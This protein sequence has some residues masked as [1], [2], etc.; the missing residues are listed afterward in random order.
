[1]AY[2]Y[3]NKDSCYRMYCPHCKTT[4]PVSTSKRWVIRCKHC[5]KVVMSPKTEPALAVLSTGKMEALA[6]E[7]ET[8]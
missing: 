3:K 4:R 2:N 7:G 5:G 8:D 6:D 1:M